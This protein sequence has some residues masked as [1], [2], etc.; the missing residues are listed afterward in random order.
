M[1]PA[2]GRPAL[3]SRPG[4]LDEPVDRVRL[5]DPQTGSFD[6][7]L[8]GFWRPLEL[9]EQVDVGPAARV[10]TRNGPMSSPSNAPCTVLPCARAR[11]QISETTSYSPL[12]LRVRPSIVI[13]LLANRWSASAA[14]S[15]GAWSHRL[16][17]RISRI[18]VRR[19]EA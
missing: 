13:P 16:A 3:E 6:G 18:T 5:P 17:T 7:R 14:W 10:S 12:I 19:P 15:Q 4:G 1:V 8:I 9:R 11:S 2:L